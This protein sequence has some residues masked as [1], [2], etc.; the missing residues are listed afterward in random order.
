MSRLLVTTIGMFVMLAV[1]V[2]P[3]LSQEEI[4]EDLQE[5]HA[6]YGDEL[7]E[8][9]SD[10]GEDCLSEAQALVATTSPA[11]GEEIWSERGRGNTAVSV[12]LDLSQGTYALN[13]I[14]P[15]HEGGWG[16][17]RLEEVIGVPESCYPW[18]SNIDGA[19]ISFPSRLPIEQECRLYATLVIERSNSNTSW[20]VSISKLSDSPPKTAEAQDWSAEGRGQKYLPMDISFA[21]GLYRLNLNNPL[22]G[23]D[24]SLWITD[25]LELP[26]HCAPHLHDIPSQFRIKENCRVLAT[27]TALLYGEN[28]DMP[29]EITI[30]KLD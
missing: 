16:N 29:W 24:G 5:L 6:E 8:Y 1:F 4:C 20:E 15:A 27:L 23:D 21:P 26:S 2:S 10:T 12:S 17:V 22:D 25:N 28:K 14:Q 19:I 18:F 7:F 13:L 3:V 30:T 9:L 11:T